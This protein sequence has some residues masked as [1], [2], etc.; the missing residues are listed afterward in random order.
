MS[1]VW[2]GDFQNL[3]NFTKWYGPKVMGS[4]ILFRALSPFQDGDTYNLNF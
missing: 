1:E 4:P 3:I 2:L